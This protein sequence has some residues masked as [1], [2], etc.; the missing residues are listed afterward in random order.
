MSVDKTVMFGHF[1][2]F[3]PEEFYE[4]IVKYNPDTGEPYTIKQWVSTTYS[5]NGVVL[6]DDIVED[7]DYQNIY[8]VEVGGKEYGY[9][10]IPI[11]S[12]DLREYGPPIEYSE[13]FLTENLNKL[14]KFLINM[15]GEKDAA[16]LFNTTK[17]ISFVWYY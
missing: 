7:F 10:G 13:D 17:L 4:D 12:H 3:E 2:W 1:V 14:H 9:V 6:S 11:V 5:C 15:F 16:K 8:Y